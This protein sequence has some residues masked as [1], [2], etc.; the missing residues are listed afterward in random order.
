MSS[1]SAEQL[2]NEIIPEFGETNI[3]LTDEAAK[4]VY[5]LKSEEGDLN[6]KLRI[7]ISGGGC[8]GFQYNFAFETDKAIDDIEIIKQIDEGTVE[9]IIDPMSLQLVTGATIDFVEDTQGERFV[10]RNPNASTT[11]GCGSSFSV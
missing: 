9:V 4:K 3:V 11:C 5:A 7:S 1:L 2:N 10:V 6:L 8:S